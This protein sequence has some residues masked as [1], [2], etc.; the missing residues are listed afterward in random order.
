M[1]DIDRLVPVLDGFEAAGMKRTKG[2]SEVAAGRLQ[3]VRNGRRTF[4]R[5][6]ELRRYIN[7][8]GEPKA[9]QVAPSK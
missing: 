4:V 5:A 1:V 9:T 8:L 3:V 7:E 2:Y 6:S